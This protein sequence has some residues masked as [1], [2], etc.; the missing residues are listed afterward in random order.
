MDWKP[1]RTSRALLLGLVAAA[2]LAGCQGSAAPGSG[3]GAAPAFSAEGLWR[4]VVSRSGTDHEAWALVFDGELLLG[5][6]G[7]GVYDGRYRQAGDA[8]D[9]ALHFAGRGPDGPVDARLWVGESDLYGDLLH[10]GAADAR[11]ELHFDPAWFRSASLGR[12]AGA[13]ADLGP[14]AS[15]VSLGIDSLGRIHGSSL[16]G[17]H[18]TGE[19]WVPVP[20]RNLYRVELTV[21]TCGALNGPYRGLATLAAEH[22]PDD[23]LD[24][25]LAGP[26]GAMDWRLRWQ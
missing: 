21:E 12:L 10:A 9:G 22:A 13:W 19:A 16:D 14:G 20:S 25:V 8:V 24:V 5:S 7:N 26:A 2:G 1:T 15:G 18:Y 11:A 23:R 4:G 6:A 17:C 3:T